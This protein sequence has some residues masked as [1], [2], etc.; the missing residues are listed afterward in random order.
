[1]ERNYI[2]SICKTK[3]PNVRDFTEDDL[4]TII[5]HWDNKW[6]NSLETITRTKL[7]DKV[8]DL[9]SKYQLDEECLVCCDNLTNGDNLTFECGHKFHSSCVIK[10]LLFFSTDSYIDFINDKEK[11]STK[12]EYCCPQCKKSIDFVEFNK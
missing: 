8:F 1:M 11:N 7:V 5:I 4:K 12:I 6:L 2:N 10:H 3:R 9:W